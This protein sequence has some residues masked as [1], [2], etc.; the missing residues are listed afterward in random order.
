MEAEA[1]S[2]EHIILERRK[3]TGFY[4]SATP[5]SSES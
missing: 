4:F 1:T 5:S 3:Q 2:E